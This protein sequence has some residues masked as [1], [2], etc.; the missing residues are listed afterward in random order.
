MRAPVDDRT[1]A[2]ICAGGAL[3]RIEIRPGHPKAP[4]PLQV[5]GHVIDPEAGDLTLRVRHGWADETSLRPSGQE[6][7]DAGTR[8]WVKL[9][10]TEVPYLE[11]DASSVMEYGE[12]REL[13][14]DASRELVNEAIQALMQIWLA[15][16]N[17]VNTEKLSGG[18]VRR[19][20]RKLNRIAAEDSPIVAWEDLIRNLLM[21]GLKLPGTVSGLKFETAVGLPLPGHLHKVNVRL[22]FQ[23]NDDEE[24]LEVAVL[25][26]DAGNGAAALDVTLTELPAA[27]RDG[28]GNS[29][30][31]FLGP[32]RSV[33][34]EE[35][36]RWL[37]LLEN[38]GHEFVFSE[39]FP[40]V[41]RIEV[42]SQ[43]G[44][45]IGGDL[46]VWNRADGVRRSAVARLNRWSGEYYPIIPR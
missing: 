17:R 15:A 3:D 28:D 2:I 42:A 36:S 45:P 25:W 8:I 22:R 26:S 10:D 35:A 38:V 14:A 1:F 16:T 37:A 4:V 27:M 40:V 34:I 12:F 18:S 31:G 43:M 44:M 13:S 21:A 39:V 5:I 46:A 23:P 6:E 30:R 20:L 11:D 32:V 41:Q 24:A 19:S 33:A 7:L 29:S 9:N